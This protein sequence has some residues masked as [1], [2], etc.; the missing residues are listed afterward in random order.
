MSVVK[1]YVAAERIEVGD[2]VFIHDGLARKWRPQDG[3][4][5]EIEV[6]QPAKPIVIEAEDRDRGVETP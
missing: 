6:V 4:L 5:E 1:A 3:R 2:L